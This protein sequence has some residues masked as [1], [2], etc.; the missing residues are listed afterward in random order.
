[1]VT[2][3]IPVYNGSNFLEKAIR[4]AIA[5]TYPKIEII[6]INDGSDDNNQT[7]DIAKKFEPE[8]KYIGIGQNLGVSTAL[9]I[10]LKE[11]QGEF[12]S[13][14]SHDDLY[15]PEK[16]SRQIQRYF[17]EEN[18]NTI[19]YCNFNNINTFNNTITKDPVKH[20]AKEQFRF[21]LL[22]EGNLHGCTLL[23]PKN[24]FKIC[25]VFNEKLQTVQ[26]IDMWFRMSSIFSFVCLDEELVFFRIHEQQ[27]SITKKKIH[28]EECNDFFSQAILQLTA[29]DVMNGSGTHLIGGYTKLIESLK[30]RNFFK[31]AKVVGLRVGMLIRVNVFIRSIFISIVIFLTK[32]YKKSRCIFISIVIFLTKIYKK[33][34]LIF[35]L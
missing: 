26:D 4:S 16:I 30:R 9:N 24:A 23:I 12:I 17:K 29:I 14:L 3:L 32:I 35:K 10:G 27:D 15:H 13:W 22:S 7:E 2:I 18:P 33:S 31:A 11:A 19:L 5:Q 34:R 28:R 6:V 25:G 21:W 8:I 20:V 1:L